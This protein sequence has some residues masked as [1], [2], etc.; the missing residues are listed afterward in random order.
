M[1][2]A[3]FASSSA[4]DAMRT[5]SSGIVLQM[6]GNEDDQICSSLIRAVKVYDC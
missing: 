4:A 1:R 2:C 5:G 6:V 3:I